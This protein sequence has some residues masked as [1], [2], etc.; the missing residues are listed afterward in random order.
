MTSNQKLINWVNEWAE[1]CQPE[2]VYWCDG[3]E[4]ENTRLLGEMV[5]S[6]MAVK[7]DEKKRPG[8][9][10]FQSDPSDVARVENRTYICS[11]K[12]EDAGP[13]NNWAD[14]VEMKATLK[15]F[16]KGCMKGR[17]MYVIPFSMGPLGSDIAHIGIELTDSPY[18]VVNMKVMTRMGKAVLD[19]LGNGE[20]VPCIHS[21]GA[22]LEPGQNDSKWP[23]APIEDKYICHFP[24]TNEILSYGSGYGG[25]A[26]LGKKCFALRIASSMAKRQGWLAEHMLIMGITNPQGVKKYIAAAFPSAC[27]KTNLAMLVPS[28]AGWKVETVGDDIAWMKFGKDGQL[29]AINPEAGFF[30]VAPYTSME[31]NPNAMLSARA[32]TIFT[33]TGLTPDGDIWWEG[34]GYDAPEGTITWTNEV[35]DA[36][37]GKPAA[38]PNA[39]FSAPAFQCPAIDKDWENPTGVPIAAILF[40]GRR[41]G[42][43]PLVYQSFDWNHGVFMGSIVGSEVTAAA[44]GLKAGVRRDP[45]A[46]LPFCGYHM[47]DYFG[48]WVTIGE[49]APDKAKLPKIFNV[50]WFRKSAQG[51]FLWPGYGDNIRVLQWIFERVAG[52]ASADETAIGFVP[53]LGSI[54]TTGL[55]GVEDNMAELLTVDKGQWK[56][57]LDLVREQYATFGSRLPKELAKQ[58]IA[59]EERF[60]K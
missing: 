53:K 40:G 9:Y 21:V 45:F 17:T 47:G 36:A 14:P 26:L 10:Y 39:R 12:E 4:E 16:F 54:N 59:I 58:I 34:I 51:K 30:G 60:E 29:Y 25:N 32:N 15:G 35:Y 57:E 2:K 48:H 13:T 44:I 1:L 20:F 11:A 52:T 56:D 37:S 8:S 7:L 41:P 27:G 38:H 28:I 49:N 18:V 23:C 24:E 33:N 43:V 5:A 22:P 31:T 42:T 3:S 6:G 19:V 50:N 55:V 46:M